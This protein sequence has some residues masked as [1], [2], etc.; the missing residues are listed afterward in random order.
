MP[1]YASMARL[2]DPFQAARGFGTSIIRS[3]FCIACAI[4]GKTER[5]SKQQCDAVQP[6]VALHTLEHSI[7]EQGRGH[8]IRGA[9]RCN[10]TWI[11]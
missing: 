5:S 10:S 11:P 3:A 8:Q 2:C 1:A 6:Y 7:Q 9:A 4:A